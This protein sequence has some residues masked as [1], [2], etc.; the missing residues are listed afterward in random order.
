MSGCKVERV[1]DEYGVPLDERLRKAHERGEALRSLERR[2]GVALLRKE[3]EQA[4]VDVV[5]GDVERY[6]D[7][8]VD[9][10]SEVARE[11]VRRKLSRAGVA[12]A[13]VLESVP[14]YQTIRNHLRECDGVDT[15]REQSRDPGDVAGTVRAVEE[16]LARVMQKSA[17]QMES[18]PDVRD[19]RTSTLVTC[20]DCGETVGVYEFLGSGCGCGG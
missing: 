7:L 1:A 3:V 8:L 16:R 5:E 6:Y 11:Q 10:G 9:G 17:R 18:V 20:D 4:G 14:S 13:E 2:A 15:S 19:V 12:V